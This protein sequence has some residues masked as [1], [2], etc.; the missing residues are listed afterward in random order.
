MW[1]FPLTSGFGDPFHWTNLHV[2]YDPFH[3]PLFFMPLSLTT[4]S[5]GPFSLTNY[6][7]VIFCFV[8]TPFIGKLNLEYV[9]IF[10]IIYM[11]ISTL[12]C[13]GIFP[14]LF[15]FRRLHHIVPHI[16]IFAILITQKGN[17]FCI[18]LPLKIPF[19]LTPGVSALG[20]KRGGFPLDF[21]T[22]IWSSGLPGSIPL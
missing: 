8:R 15:L 9:K 20:W 12:I 22:G 4:N 11:Y 19:S 5:S 18:I 16:H 1:P 13:I 21:G 14:I 6:F 10:S 3:T 2:K 17:P 7:P